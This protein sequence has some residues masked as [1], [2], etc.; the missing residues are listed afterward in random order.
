MLPPTAA[1]LPPT[2][3]FCYLVP[4][5]I[6]VWYTYCY[7]L[8]ARVAE[9]MLQIKFAPH[10]SVILV[11]HDDLFLILYTLYFILYTLYR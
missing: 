4:P 5:T 2:A 9:L 7:L 11:C 1:C 6:T 3:T 10:E 8:Q